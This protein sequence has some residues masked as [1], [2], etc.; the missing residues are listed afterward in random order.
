MCIR[1]RPTF[2]SPLLSLPLQIGQHVMSAL[3]HEDTIAVLTT[4]TGSKSGQR[5][6]SIP[7]NA[8][9]VSE[10]EQLMAVVDENDTPETSPC[11]GFHCDFPPESAK[12]DGE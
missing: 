4:V 5:L 9:Q 1:D 8:R 7:L 3:N 2:V 10:V 6:V 11:V 12:S